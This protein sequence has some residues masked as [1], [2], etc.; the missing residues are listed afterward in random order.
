MIRY[1][2]TFCLPS[3]FSSG[4]SSWHKMLP[5]EFRIE[6]KMGTFLQ[7]YKLNYDGIR[8]CT[9][10]WIKKF[11]IRQETASIDWMNVLWLCKCE[12][13]SPMINDLQEVVT[14]NVKVFAEDCLIYKT[15]QTTTQSNKEDLNAFGKWKKW[16]AGGITPEEM[17]HHPY[18]KKR[19]PIKAS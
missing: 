17:Y 2:E 10:Q 3:F 18:L 8:G 9:L 6:Q 16:L 12:L 19:Y 14:S 4:F 7:L 15:N 11:L 13:R 5:M 1:N